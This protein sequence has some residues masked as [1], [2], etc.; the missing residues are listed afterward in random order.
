MHDQQNIKKKLFYVARFREKVSI[1]EGNRIKVGPEFKVL[2]KLTSDFK[3]I[4]LQFLGEE[5]KKYFIGEK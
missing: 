4:K 3:Y 5:A 2:I 1:L